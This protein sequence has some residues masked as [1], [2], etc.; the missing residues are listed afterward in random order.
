MKS[1]QTDLARH[2]T[3]SP[4]RPHPIVYTD[5]DRR[6]LMFSDGAI[7]SEMLLSDPDGLTLPYTRAIMCFVL[8]QPA[9][10][11]ILIVGLGGGS[12]VKFCLRHLPGARITVLEI[13]EQVIAL[14]ASFAI[15]PDNE[16]LRVVHA[17]AAQYIATLEAQVDVL[18]I[19]GFDAHG[20]PPQLASADFYAAC[21]RAMRP[22][23]VVVVNLHSSEPDYAGI[24]Q[25]LRIAFD[26]RTCRF[27]GIA[28][29]NHILFAVAA[30]NGFTRA[31]LLQRLLARTQGFGGEL[32]RLLA[33]AVVWRLRRHARVASPAANIHDMPGS[34]TTSACNRNE[35]QDASDLQP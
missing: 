27:K 3:G 28:L 23:G 30:A 4:T 29:H 15:P 16:R 35:P 26:D 24:A 1:A 21:R 22:A 7:Q 20:Q 11:E 13:D 6:W 10:R 5:G 19:D 34:G 32:N 17:D 31:H 2:G 25:R 33:R 18:I 12:L 9:P 14:R 8:F